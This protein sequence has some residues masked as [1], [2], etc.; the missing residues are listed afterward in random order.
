MFIPIC[1]LEWWLSAA[2]LGYI[3]FFFREHFFELG[4]RRLCILLIIGWLRHGNSIA[5]FKSMA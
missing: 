3:V 1:I 4:R 5:D 2:G